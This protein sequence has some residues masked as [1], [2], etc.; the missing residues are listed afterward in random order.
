[1]MF[2]LEVRKQIGRY[3]LFVPR[4]TFQHT[5]SHDARHRLSTGLSVEAPLNFTGSEAFRRRYEA[6]CTLF[7][8]FI[9]GLQRTRRITNILTIYDSNDC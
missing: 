8:E 9:A 4:M 6:P 3:Y 1:M 7:L 5:N 2:L